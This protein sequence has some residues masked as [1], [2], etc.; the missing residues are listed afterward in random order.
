MEKRIRRR[1]NDRILTEAIGRY[2]I[3]PGNIH[4]LDGFESFMYEFDRD[5]RPFILR[6]AHTI[7]RSEELIHGEVDWINFLARGGASVAGAVLSSNDRLVEAIDDG[8]GGSFLATAF[9]RAPGKPPIK[10]DWTPETFTA[11]GRLIGKMHALAQRYQPA[12]PRWRRPHWDD[13]LMLDTERWLKPDDA[14]VIERYRELL[15]YLRGLPRDDPRAYNLIHQDA[16]AGNFFID[17]TGTITLFDFDDCV[18]GWFIYDL[19]MVIFYAAIGKEGVSAFIQA[20]MV[21]FLRGYTEE[22]HLDPRWL[23]EIPNFLKL[24][25]IDLYAAIHRSFDVENLDDPWC[26]RFMDGRKQR[27]ENDAPVIDFDFTSLSVHM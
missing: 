17:E 11:Y 5:G 12:D 20:F 6:L 25:E 19:A 18:Y 1:Y 16:H 9:V 8:C 2:G 10:S 26:M 13:P 22:N 27:I 24:R 4:L 21:D 14:G 3:E 15:A 7:R 23:G